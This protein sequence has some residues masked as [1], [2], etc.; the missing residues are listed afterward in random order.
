MLQS[1]KGRGTVV[2]VK[3]VGN[4]SSIWTI[5]PPSRDLMTK[6]LSS[7]K[8]NV[9]MRFSYEFTRW[10]WH[11]TFLR[12]S[13]RFILGEALSV[14]KTSS[15]FCCR[16]SIRLQLQLVFFPSFALRHHCAFPLSP[17]GHLLL[18][19]P[20][21]SSSPNFLF[22]SSA[23]FSWSWS[24]PPAPHL[25]LLPFP[26]S[27]PSAFPPH[28]TSCLPASPPFPPPTSLPPISTSLLPAPPPPSAAAT[29]PLHHPPFPLTRH[30]FAF[31]LSVFH[32][33]WFLTISFPS[34]PSLKF[35]V[36]KVLFVG[37]S[38]EVSFM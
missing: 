13:A 6:Y 18:S 16:L 37:H 24:L 26:P 33:S 10:G 5:S 30:L 29:F 28:P 7:N 4:S 22:C 31:S 34:F 1:F 35:R 20:S 15:I 8:D 38:P 3:I 2:Q 9:T 23:L 25:L 12:F 32:S 11:S 27:L 21:S 17:C 14:F 36:R 19:S